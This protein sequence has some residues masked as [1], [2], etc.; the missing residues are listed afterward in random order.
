MIKALN[1]LARHDVNKRQLNELGLM[2]IYVD[3]V[4]DKKLASD[5]E[6]VEALNGIW[7]MTFL[8]KA[9]EEYRKCDGSIDCWLKNNFY[10]FYFLF[11]KIICILY[12]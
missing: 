12:F 4:R 8:P 6:R 10:N 1:A 3:I 11:H 9:V 5:E 7:V 2:Q